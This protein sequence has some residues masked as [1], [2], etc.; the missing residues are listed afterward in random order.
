MQPADPAFDI[1]DPGLMSDEKR[2]PAK[3]Q[4]PKRAERNIILQKNVAPSNATEELEHA[5]T[6][7]HCEGK[8]V[9]PAGLSDHANLMTELHELTRQ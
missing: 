6:A 3:E 9:F 8:T 2:S 1:S 5:G 4:R 7:N